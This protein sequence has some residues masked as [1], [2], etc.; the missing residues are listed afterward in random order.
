MKRLLAALTLAIAMFGIAV[1]PAEPA[2]IAAGSVDGGGRFFAVDQDATNTCGVLVVGPCQL[3]DLDA[4]L[5]S[6]VTG[7]FATA[8]GDL[9]VGFAVQTSDK[10]PVNRLDSTGT[11]FSNVGA[12]SHTFIGVIS[13]TGFIGPATT[14]TTTGAGQ[15]SH[16]GLGYGDSNIAMQW[17]NDPAN[18]QGA[19]D[20]SINQPGNIIDTFADAAGPGN[21]DSFSHNGGPFAVDDPGLFSMTLRFEGLIEPGVRLTGRE[22]TELKS[23]VVSS[24]M[25][26]MLVGAGLTLAAIV[27]AARRRR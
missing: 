20:T 15:W 18:G 5:N 27:P 14:A 9:T 11:Q 17:F 22:M 24:P 2:L 4:A 6:L 7:A 12:V 25:S 19:L 8:G 1:L 13:D 10:G 23:T 26:L 16:L 21:P 3:P